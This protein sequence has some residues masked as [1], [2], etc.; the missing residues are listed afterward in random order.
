MCK[1][2]TFIILIILSLNVEKKV[3][4]DVILIKISNVSHYRLEGI[5]LFHP[6]PHST[7][8]IDVQKKW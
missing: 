1:E 3:G 2:I 4:M 8:S 5:F 6:L 7:Y